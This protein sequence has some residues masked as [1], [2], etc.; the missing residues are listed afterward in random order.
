VITS[1]QGTVATLRGVAAASVATSKDPFVDALNRSL[2]TGAP[3]PGAGAPYV[4]N[5]YNKRF[6]QG[7]YIAVV[8]MRGGA[9]FSSGPAG[10][11]VVPGG[12]NSIYK[13]YRANSTET[14]RRL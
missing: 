9:P 8:G 3:N 13:F 1:L 2:F 7:F 6:S 11:I 5:G 14:W 12:G 4:I 10:V